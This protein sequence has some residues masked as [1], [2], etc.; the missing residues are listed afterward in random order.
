[1]KIV[2]V[3][4]DPVETLGKFA[5]CMFFGATKPF[6][7]HGRWRQGR[8]GRSDRWPVPNMWGLRPGQIQSLEVNPLN[9]I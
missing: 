7:V 2:Y 8:R 4:R 3:A 5:T 1:M 6:V 9:P